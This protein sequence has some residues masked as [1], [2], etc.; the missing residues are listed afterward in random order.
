V[1]HDPIS[2]YQI[3]KL[4]AHI[5]ACNENIASLRKQVDILNNRL[6]HVDNALTR[7]KGILTGLIL[8]AGIAGSIIG[9]AI[10][11]FFKG[12]GS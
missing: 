5:E 8:A 6:T 3:G 1:E 7:S 4:V 12:G 2:P 10:D 9:V 11:N